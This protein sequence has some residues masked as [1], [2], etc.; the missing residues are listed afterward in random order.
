V[1]N[2]YLLNIFL[3]QWIV[4]WKVGPAQGNFEEVEHQDIIRQD[5][6]LVKV[7]PQS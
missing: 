4:I 7:D 3:W 5:E 2:K 6:A 1:V